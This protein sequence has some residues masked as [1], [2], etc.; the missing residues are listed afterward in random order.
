MDK[1]DQSRLKT[2]QTDP[3]SQQ[4]VPSASELSLPEEASVSQE[5]AMPDRQLRDSVLSSAL[6]SIFQSKSGSPSSRQRG[7]SALVIASL[8][9]LLILLA[10]AAFSVWKFVIAPTLV[11]DVQ[12]YQVQMQNTTQSVGGGGIIYPLQQLDVTYPETERVLSIQVKS[13]DQVSPNQSLLQ[14]DLVQLNIQIKQAEDAVAAAQNYLNSVSASGNVTQI[15][16]AQQQYNIAQSRY[17][18]LMAQVA[19]PLV[20]GG[21]LVS[22]M[23][24][25]VTTIN[26]NPGQVVAA[27]T[28]LLT[29]MDESTVIVRA[30]VPL[31]NLGQVHVGQQVRV[32][33]SSLST[34]TLPGTVSSVIPQAD[35]QTD[36]FEVWVSINNKDKMLLP[37]MSAFVRIQKPAK[38]FVV[39]RLCVLDLDSDPKVFVVGNDSRAHLRSVHVIGRS[40]D[41]IFIDAGVS[42][43]DRVVLVGLANL[44]D[45]QRVRVVGTSAALHRPER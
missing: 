30:K 12:L 17:N 39:P 36:T 4:V 15:A 10:G 2:A 7:R 3:C 9:G 43:A 37:G 28:T 22:P 31:A 44:Q 18:A 32:T 24:G 8:L 27:N 5:Q 11:R 16:A 19:S 13:G 1:P 6:P 38:A 20:H 21:D 42:A 23:G 33:P 26:V 25:I 35:P 45:G 29:I 14:L 34:V 41:T 40:T